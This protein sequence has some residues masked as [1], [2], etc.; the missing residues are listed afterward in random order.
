MI[1]CRGTGAHKGRPYERD[2]AR[3]RND[4]LLS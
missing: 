2:A 3:R 4:G 1:A